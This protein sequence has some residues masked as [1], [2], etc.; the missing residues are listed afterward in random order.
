[1]VMKALL[2]QENS[3]KGRNLC[4]SAPPL[5]FTTLIL[6]ARIFSFIKI[7]HRWSGYRA[8]QQ[9]F[10]SELPLVVFIISA[11]NLIYRLNY[12]MR[13]H[14]HKDRSAIVI[15][16]ALNVHRF[17]MS[18]F[19]APNVEVDGCRAGETL[20]YPRRKRHRIKGYA[21]YY[22]LDFVLY[23]SGS[24]F[25]RSHDSLYIS[26]CGS[27]NIIRFGCLQQ[28]LSLPLKTVVKEYVCNYSMRWENNRS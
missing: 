20:V 13:N 14:N 12:A 3:G 22:G 9:D 11:A 25:E 8:E 23:V 16:K 26:I 5:R 15:L 17:C 21:S 6:V 24:G 10:S 7:K 27:A 4:S 19:P 28:H 1:M 2:A 18:T